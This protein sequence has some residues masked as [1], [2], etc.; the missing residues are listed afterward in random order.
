[1]AGRRGWPRDAGGARFAHVVGAPAVAT[2]ALAASGTG[3]AVLVRRNVTLAQRELECAN[4]PH[5]FVELIPR[6]GRGLFVLNV[7]SKPTLQHRFGELLRRA[8]TAANGAPLLVAG[9]FNAPYGAW[10]Y[11]R[12]R[13]SRVRFP[14]AFPM[15]AEM[16]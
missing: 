5:V 4:I 13:R 9:D 11:M 1:M 10:G 7:Y 6:R 8:S 3:V 14:A 2:V 15:E 16:L 12:T